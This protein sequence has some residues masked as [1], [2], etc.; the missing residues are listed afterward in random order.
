MMTPILSSRYTAVAGSPHAGARSRC[1]GKIVMHRAAIPNHIPRMRILRLDHVKLVR[2]N[3]VVLSRSYRD[4][5]M[6]AMMRSEALA[7]ERDER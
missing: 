2:D 7:V 5:K 1:D 3:D 4:R 6:K